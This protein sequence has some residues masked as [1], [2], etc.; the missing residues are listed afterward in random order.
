MIQEKYIGISCMLF[1]SGNV[2]PNPEQAENILSEGSW[3]HL[4]ICV[5]FM[6]LFLIKTSNYK[7]KNIEHL[8][9][10]MEKWKL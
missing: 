7:L 5:E 9:F 8:I 1:R 3:N 10:H 2:S 4:L 6:K